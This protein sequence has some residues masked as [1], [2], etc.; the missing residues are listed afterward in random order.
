MSGHVKFPFKATHVTRNHCPRIF[1]RKWRANDA[2]KVRKRVRNERKWIRRRKPSQDALWMKSSS[3]Y[4][5]HAL[6]VMLDH[7]ALK[8]AHTQCRRCRSHPTGIP[9]R[10]A[11]RGICCK[12]N[13]RCAS[14]D[15]RTTQTSSFPVLRTHR[16]SISYLSRSGVV[17]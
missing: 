16:A 7:G 1:V 11:T 5:D 9:G 15:R 10:P 2:R 14:D 8:R 12:R 13:I 3:V 17:G 6:G 4:S